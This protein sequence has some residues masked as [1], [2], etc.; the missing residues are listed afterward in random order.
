LLFIP[1][2][3]RIIVVSAGIKRD[4]IARE[5]GAGDWKCIH[6]QLTGQHGENRWII[7]WEEAFA[8]SAA[9]LQV[10]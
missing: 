10:T 2:F 8:S 3:L 6:L 9:G 4:L 7:R 1:A 5:F